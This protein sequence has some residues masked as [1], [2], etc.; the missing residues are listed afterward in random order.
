ML[1]VLTG[2][3]QTGKTRW[4]QAL[5][6]ELREGGVAVSGVLAPGV[7]RELPEGGFEKLGIDNVLLPQGERLAFARRRDLALAEGAFV[8]ESQSAQANLKW[9]MPE[10]ALERVNAHLASLAHVQP[11][12]RPSLLVI[13]EVGRLELLRN[14]GLVEAL[15]L[16]DGGPCEAYRHVLVIVREALLEAARERFEP[17]W[18]P[19]VVIGADD[20]GR[21]AVLNAF[22]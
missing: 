20:A 17:V 14:G 19:L 18:G 6:D 12:G 15:R 1:F 13:D 2:D 10:G 8:A 11:D 16:L 5:L 22:A 7:W 4:L 9:E 21:A 3:V